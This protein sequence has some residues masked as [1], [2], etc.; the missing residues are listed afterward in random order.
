[1]QRS[2]N[3]QTVNN[4]PVPVLSPSI[5][6]IR[7]AEKP[8]ELWP[9]PGLS[10]EGKEDEKSLVIRGWERAGAWAVLFGTQHGAESYPKPSAIYAPNPEAVSL[11]ETSPR[12]FQTVIPLG[13]RLG[14]TPVTTYSVGQEAQLVSETL[15]IVRESSLFVGNIKRSPRR[16]HQALPASRR[17]KT[18]RKS[19]MK[20][21]M[22]LSSVS[23]GY[24]Q[25]LPGRFTSSAHV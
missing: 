2:D 14:I 17:S 25:R 5:L 13:E 7:H 6:I 23:T 3:L 8:G 1:V 20:L 12:P 4:R 24:L 11:D 22:M 21:D 18:C 15:H 10:R 9:G 19:G 16:S